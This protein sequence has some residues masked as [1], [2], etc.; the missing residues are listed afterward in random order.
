MGTELN[1]RKTK[2]LF[3]FIFSSI[4]SFYVQS[5]DTT[6]PGDKYISLSVEDVS[7]TEVW[8][9]VKTDLNKYPQDFDLYE[10]GE[11]KYNFEIRRSDTTLFIKFLQPSTQYSFFIQKQQVQSNKT[12]ITTL[13]TTSH[14][15]NWQA[16]TFGGNGSSHINDVAIIDENNIWAVGSIYTFDSISTINPNF[17]NA[18]Y[19]DGGS[20]KLT[21]IEVDFRGSLIMPPLES[22]FAFSLTDIWL[23]GSLPIHGDGS[24]W[25]IYDLRS[26]LDPDLSLSTAW[27]ANSKDVYFVGRN[28]SIA[29]YDGKSWKKIESGTEVNLTDVYGNEDGSIVWAVWPGW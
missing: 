22:V 3:L 25:E 1:L 28:G 8:L 4:I 13:D 9:N 2:I 16:F 15:I 7:S 14:N 11:F 29:H 18:V 5:C 19:W 17:S 20:W 12:Q 27:G 23:I 21:R 6:E 24:N 26:E 10:N